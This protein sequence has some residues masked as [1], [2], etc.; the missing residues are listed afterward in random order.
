MRSPRRK[1]ARTVVSSTV[2]ELVIGSGLCFEGRGEHELK[3]VPGRWRLMAVTDEVEPTPMR[4]TP[5][6]LRPSD[7]VLGRVARRFP[8]AVRAATRAAGRRG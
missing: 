1:V 4:A 6:P 8:G 5:M 2:A 7:Q 3:G